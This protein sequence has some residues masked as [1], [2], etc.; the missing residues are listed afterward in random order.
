MACKKLTSSNSVEDASSY[1]TASVKPDAN[2]LV[3]LFVTHSTPIFV[4]GAPTTPTVSGNGLVWLRVQTVTFGGQ[5]DRRLT[6]F[7]AMGTAPAEGAVT[8]DFGGQNQDYCAWSLFEYTDVDI[9]GS[10]AA[11]VAQSSVAAGTGATLTVALTPSADSARNVSVG[12]LALELVAEPDRPVSS[13]AGFTEIDQMNPDQLF[14]KGTSLQ[15]QDASPAVSGVSWTWT[16]AENAAAI[17]LEVKAVPTGTTP[18][19]PLTTDEALIK[20]FEPVL[21]FHPDEKFFPVDAKRFIEQAA[22]W[23][24][25][26]PF[27]D[28]ATW[29]GAPG[30]P[31]PRRPQ[32]AAGKLAAAPN[33]G[34]DY[35]F[36]ETFGKGQDN[37]FLELGGWKDT[38][39][40]PEAGVTE[41]SENVYT[42]RD[43][44]ADLYNNE[45]EAS[46]F[47]YHAEVFAKTRLEQIAQSDNN[48]KKILGQLGEH[49]RLVCYYLFFPAHEQSVGRERCTGV[50]A[51][52]VAC[53]A[54]DWQC[55]AV[56]LKGDG[57]DTAE[58]F[59]P[60]F[61]GLTGSRRAAVVQEDG[62]VVFRPYQFDDEDRTAITVEAWRPGQPATVDGH[63]RVYVARGTHSL[64]TKPGEHQVDPFSVNKEPRQCGTLDG[65]GPPE[66]PPPDRDFPL[67]TVA[68]I[69]AKI[70]AAGLANVFAVGFVAAVLEFFWEYP[71]APFGAT[72]PPVDPPDPDQAPAAA[73]AGKTVRP[74][75]LTVPDAGEDVVDWR[76]QRSL[77][78][79]GRTY[80]SVVERGPKQPW[81]P[82]DDNEQGF[83]GRWGQHVTTDG[84]GRRAGP[85]FPNYAAM[86]LGALADG[87]T[88]QQLE[89]DG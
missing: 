48:L 40:V 19:P 88:R 24:S 61:L 22:L 9:D 82:G 76:S 89:L 71:Y 63:P 86:F 74:R 83:W 44:I 77:V 60:K 64:Y 11:A 32:V 81:W 26:E 14:G 5:N 23:T 70:A 49:P 34:D 43:S 51:N 36:G 84:L 39:G 7:R 69:V 27:D 79:E 52:E 6:C 18:P 31:F 47:W 45:L 20:R 8:M 50:A 12:A 87:D 59:T 37:R 41:S 54:G 17:A 68:A 58:G 15:T 65:P 46:R 1:Q 10:G 57:A 67:D 28:K 38:N 2:A 21:F 29:G 72:P 56:M 80:S 55:I 66:P 62:S 85:R 16:G 13:G 42:D 73:G 53:H 3:L 30:D 33:E 4:V 25:R 35:R 75:D 78:L